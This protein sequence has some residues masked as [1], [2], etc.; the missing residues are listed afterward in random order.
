MP[1]LILFTIYSSIKDNE[2][3]VTLSNELCAKRN[4]KQMSAKRNEKQIW[5]SRALESGRERERESVKWGKIRKKP[6]K[7]CGINYKNICLSTISILF[8]TNSLVRESFF[9]CS[10]HLSFIELNSFNI[11]PYLCVCVYHGIWSFITSACW[12]AFRVFISFSSSH[13]IIERQ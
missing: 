10:N 13:R 2:Q 8:G 3:I 5:W 1:L 4:E 6:W 7:P 12:P 9:N 11:V